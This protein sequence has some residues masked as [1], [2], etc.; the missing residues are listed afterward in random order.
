MTK[1]LGLVAGLVAGIL[2][3]GCGHT[4]TWHQTFPASERFVLVMGDE[5]VVDK[6]TGLVWQKSPSDTKRNWFIS[7]SA[8]YNTEVGGRLGWRTPTMAELTSLVD[9]TQSSP[10]LPAGHP[11]SL[12]LSSDYWS[13]TT[14]A[15]SSRAWHMSFSNGFQG[16]SD[17]G[18]VEL[19]VWCVRGGQG[20]DG[21]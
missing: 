10:T 11:F 7:L 18:A 9:R 13:A 2:V 21:Q 17:K 20:I 3:T 1:E 6:E 12:A 5:A 4:P 19:L 8:C 14:V 16:N 15:G